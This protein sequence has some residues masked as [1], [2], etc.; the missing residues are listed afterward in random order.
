MLKN[1]IQF[2]ITFVFLFCFVT[3]CKHNSQDGYSILTIQPQIAFVKTGDSVQFVITNKSNQTIIKLTPNIGFLNAANWY[4]APSSIINDSLPILITVSNNQEDL[5]A[6]VYIVKST[7]ND[8]VISFNNTI[9]PLMVA[10]CNFTACHGNGSRAGKVELSS[11]DSLMRFVVPHQ[12]QYS[13]LFTCLLKTD[14]LRRMPPAGPLHAYK[15]NYI[16]NWIEQ[17]AIAN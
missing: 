10:N 14:V 4:V 13:I 6:K 15:I 17:G 2:I 5:S 12:P 1:N 16:K 9:L 11:Y 3:A 7:E 8:T